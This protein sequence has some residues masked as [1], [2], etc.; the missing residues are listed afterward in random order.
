MA[1]PFLTYTEQI[2]KL[3]EKNLVI[4]DAPE[5]IEILKRISY[6]S[7]ISGYKHL[8][9]NKTT[10]KYND[11]TRFE[12]IVIFYEF[13]EKLRNIML[14][15][16]FKVERHLKSLYSYYFSQELGEYK[17]S[18]KH[19]M[20]Y[21]YTTRNKGKIET[22]I[23]EKMNLKE[24]SERHH[25]IKHHIE[26]HQNVPIWVLLN[27]FTFGTFSKMFA[28]SKQSIQSKVSKAFEGINESDLISLL[29]VLSKYRNVCAHNERLFNYKTKTDIPDLPLHVKLNLLKK[30][31]QY[32]YGK[33]DLF[34][35]LIG[36]KYLLEQEKFHCLCEELEDLI[37][38]FVEKNTSLSREVLLHEMGFPSYWIALKEITFS[39]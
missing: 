19:P 29:D 14:N 37:N 6:F 2:R 1:K 16:T 10:K 20:N 35:V 7:L 39:F 27:T 30:G 38:W 8:F 11:N 32:I 17:E 25:Y 36:L 34:A 18:Y 12:D 24:L 26:N 31:N 3:R 5:A 13:D 23:R 15:Y 9:K 21:E 33:K 4:N 22:L 28:L